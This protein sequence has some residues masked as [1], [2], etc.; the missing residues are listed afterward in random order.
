MHVEDV[1]NWLFTLGIVYNT[2]QDFLVNHGI[3]EHFMYHLIFTFKKEELLMQFKSNE[4]HSIKIIYEW[5]K[6]NL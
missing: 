2:Y 3:S 6:M 5:K 4:I 1:I